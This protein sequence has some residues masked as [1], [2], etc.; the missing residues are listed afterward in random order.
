MNQ[1][2]IMR[3]PTKDIEYPSKCP[4]CGEDADTSS[5]VTLNPSSSGFERP[6]DIRY[7]PAERYTEQKVVTGIQQ[8]AYVQPLSR[9]QKTYLGIPTCEFH[10]N[11]S[12]HENRKIVVLFFLLV[13]LFASFFTIFQITN[14]YFLG[15]NWFPSLVVLIGILSIISVLSVLTYF[16]PPIQRAFKILDISADG[17]YIYLQLTNQEYFEEFGI[18]N[19]M[20]IEYLSP[21]Q[22]KEEL[23]K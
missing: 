20:H 9:P 4:V 12:I 16:P 7:Y 23:E 5:Y 2:Y 13:L 21:K 11:S 14:S 19:R 22:M 10:E 17:K 1:E 3:V 18:L 6:R 8:S 15:Q